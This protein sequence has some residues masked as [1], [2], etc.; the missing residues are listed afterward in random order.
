MTFL[1]VYEVDDLA[2]DLDDAGTPLLVPLSDSLAEAVR[3]LEVDS[4]VDYGT[5]PKPDPDLAAELED[6]VVSGT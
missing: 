4:D 3:R 5:I 1:A 2:A 6:C